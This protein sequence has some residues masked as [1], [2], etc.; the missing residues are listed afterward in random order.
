MLGKA[1][2]GLR[3]L[4]KAKGGW[5]QSAAMPQLSAL[6]GIAALCRPPRGTVCSS[7]AEYRFQ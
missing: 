6:W 5:W 4:P 1:Q 3:P 7:R 2:R